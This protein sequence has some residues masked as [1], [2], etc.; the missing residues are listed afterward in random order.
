MP[1]SH[2]IVGAGPT[3]T[4]TALLLA[5]AGDS[6]T[7][8]TRRGNGP[9][10][11]NIARVALDATD[12]EALARLVTGH[13]T[14]FNCAM[15]RYDRW[16]Q[17]FPPIAAAML[18]AARQAGAALVML[19]NA[20]GYG[21]AAGPL[22]EDLPMAPHTA[23][24]RVRAAMWQDALA[25][26]VRVAE[27]RASDYL[28]HHAS[29]LYTLMTLPALLRGERAVYAGDLDA[30]HSWSFTRDV[31]ATLVAAARDERSWGRAWHVPSHD[32]SARE[33]SQHFA[34]AAGLP[35]PVL[36]RMPLAALRTLGET[37]S[38]LA[39]VVEMAYLYEQPLRL[40]AQATRAML[41]IAA[42]PLEQVLADTLA[43]TTTAD[44]A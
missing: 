19:G 32:L 10:H 29:S 26:G 41:G 17:D 18:H 34:A 4:H 21:E 3:G 31:A 44:A 5:E 12:G 24:G 13:A 40:D 20:Y 38:I 14:L 30:P 2:L 25:S 8:A 22:T 15:P 33:L 23:K 16:P 7:L 39:E 27:V 43:P 36:E 37:D 42:S 1:C 35:A 28:G 9:L 6:V 11:P